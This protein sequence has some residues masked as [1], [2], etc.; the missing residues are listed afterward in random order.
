MDEI[1]APK[2]I[3]QYLDPTRNNKSLKLAMANGPFG[4]MIN[5]QSDDYPLAACVLK[6]NI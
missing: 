1:K 3:K 5:F 6:K 4:A 2:L